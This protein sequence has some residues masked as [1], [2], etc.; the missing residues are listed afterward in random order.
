MSTAD[1]VACGLG[2]LAIL[3]TVASIWWDARR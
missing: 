2:V 3:V 1:A